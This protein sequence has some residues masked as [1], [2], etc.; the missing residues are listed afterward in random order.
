V[1][2]AVIGGIFA[3]LLFPNGSRLSRHCRMRYCSFRGVSRGG[4][5][6]L[7]RLATRETGNGEDRQREHGANFRDHKILSAN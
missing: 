1:A 7:L 3:G 5:T 2:V 6:N 4:R